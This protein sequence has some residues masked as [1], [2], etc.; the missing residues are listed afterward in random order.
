ML[1]LILS[2]AFVLL[3]VVFLLFILVN[4]YKEGGLAFATVNKIKS[5][6]FL[7]E[8]R[9]ELYWS[10]STD[11]I[12]LGEMKLTSEEANYLVENKFLEY[13][14]ESH[15]WYTDKTEDEITLILMEGA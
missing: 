10:V 14:E 15:Q 11:E 4:S 13:C 8:K 5:F 7:K 2:I 3:P 6:I 1:S 12:R 9:K